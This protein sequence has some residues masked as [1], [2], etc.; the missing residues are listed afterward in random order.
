MLEPTLSRL[1][2]QV[3]CCPRTQQP[4]RPLCWLTGL[5]LRRSM[6]A[7]L[8]WYSCC[9]KGTCAFLVLAAAPRTER[10]SLAM[11][12][13]VRFAERA[14]T[15]RSRSSTSASLYL[16][17]TSHLLMTSCEC[18]AAAPAHSPHSLIARQGAHREAYTGTRSA[19]HTRRVTV[20]AAVG[21]HTARQGQANRLATCT[22]VPSRGA[23][24]KARR[25]RTRSQPPG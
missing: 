7:C 18:D 22:G 24:R 17:A 10:S 8:C 11:T 6:R 14:S 1:D 25:A 3:T 23:S 4:P 5:R 13:S 2:T 21:M 19:S 12:T 9:P 15:T 16:H 20:A